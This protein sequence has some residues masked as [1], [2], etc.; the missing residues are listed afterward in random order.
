M[1]LRGSAQATT[2]HIVFV[3]STHKWGGVKTWTLDFG[4]VLKRFGHDVT[5]FGRPG[6]FMAKAASLKLDARPFTFGPDFNPAAV[7]HF[8]AAF[9][10]TRPDVV[11]VN[12]G[13]DMRSA[14]ISAR[15]IGIPVVHRIGLPDDVRKG[16]IVRM[17]HRW[18]RP[19]YLAPCRFVK[20]GFLANLPFVR[21]DEV[22][23]IFNGKIP[24]PDP[25]HGVSTP[26]ELV[27]TSQLS[28]DKGHLDV[29]TALAGLKRQ[30]HAFR[31][32]VA[33]TGIC[34]QEVKRHARLLGLERDIV[35]H[36][37][38][39]DVRGL[40]KGKDVFVLP[41]HSEGLPNSLLEALAEGLVPIAYR[42]G[43]IA[44]AWP[45]VD[46]L[47]GLLVPQ[48][49][50]ADGLQRALGQVLIAPAANVLVWKRAAREWLVRSFSLERQARTLEAWLTS[51]N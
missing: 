39:T 44:E 22:T 34:E 47:D 51:L 42:I 4:T 49:S 2:L 48:D 27:T 6:P 31:W 26:L 3:N 35:W 7:F 9:R 43:G 37:F 8:L 1:H 30:G 21:A 16:S 15:M 32:H 36:G 46:G 13:K 11:I 40:L 33:G 19:R 24:A 18:V 12:V 45:C 29:L 20:Q 10:K 5:V 14:G 23:V 41:S 28:P 17:L 50:G 38:T 25:P